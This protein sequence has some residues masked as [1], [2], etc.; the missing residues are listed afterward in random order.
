MGDRMTTYL[1]GSWV[2][3]AGPL[4]PLMMALLAWTLVG[5]TPAQR[6]DPPSG[7]T[8]SAHWSP[9][10]CQNEG[11]M[12]NCKPGYG[13]SGAEGGAEQAY[14]KNDV[15]IMRG[16]CQQGSHYETGRGCIWDQPRNV[17]Q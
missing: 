3:A 14:R 7:A 1:A 13:L 4:A 6:T 5:C 16:L 17:S 15:L 2:R 9:E 12:Y 11:N 10:R 8:S